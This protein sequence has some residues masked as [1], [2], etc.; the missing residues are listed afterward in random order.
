MIGDQ[1]KKLRNDRRISQTGLS[2][3]LRISEKTLNNWETNKSRPSPEMVKLIAETLVVSYDY[4]F[5]KEEMVSDGYISGDHMT[6][7]NFINWILFCFKNKNPCQIYISNRVFELKSNIGH[8]P[9]L[10]LS[11]T[12][13]SGISDIDFI[14][15]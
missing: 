13:T 7:N 1:I 15:S 12:A 4:L 11:V 14:N 6:T 5:N 2:T 3:L 9:E 10:L 8:P